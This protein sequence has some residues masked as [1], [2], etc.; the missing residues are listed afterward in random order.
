MIDITDA[1]DGYYADAIPQGWD[2]GACQ[3]C[4]FRAKAGW[5]GCVHVAC[6]AA[7]RYDEQDVRF[8]KLS[9]R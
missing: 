8:V 6:R 2:T 1:P 3:H 9:P 4:D 7:Q 5:D